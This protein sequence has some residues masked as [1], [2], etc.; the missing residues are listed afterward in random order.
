M[1]LWISVT[2]HCMRLHYARDGLGSASQRWLALAQQLCHVECGCGQVV[3]CR[4]SAVTAS[5]LS[6]REQDLHEAY[7]C[8]QYYNDS[9]A[10]DLKHTHQSCIEMSVPCTWSWKLFGW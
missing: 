4:C 9:P 1:R 2:S 10:G 6:V 5:Q 7:A 8:A 3:E